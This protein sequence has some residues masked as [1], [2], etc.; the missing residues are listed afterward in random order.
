[1][2][3]RFRRV[4]ALLLVVFMAAAALH[5]QQTFRSSAVLVPVDARA[6]DRD[7]RPVT[8][9][10]PADFIVLEDGVRQT[11]QH[12]VSQAFTPQPAPRSGGTL[13][14][15]ATPAPAA[16]G[17]LPQQTARVF[18]IVLGRGRLQVPNNGLVSCG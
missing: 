3:H 8:H 2:T 9:L 6:V 18:L 5:A 15:I 4:P 7:G 13:R 10:T 11:V 14:T 1:M 17:A 16:E 12:F